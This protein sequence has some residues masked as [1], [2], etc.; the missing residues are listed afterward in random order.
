M[1][2]CWHLHELDPSWEPPA[3]SL[4]RPKHLDAVLARLSGQVGTVARLARALVER[5]RQLTADIVAQDKEL[6]ALVEQLAPTLLEICGCSVQLVRR[7]RAGQH[8]PQLHVR[9]QPLD[10]CA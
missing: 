6:E 10:G 7:A 2:E 8:E 4:W 1:H 5:C 9:P 3:R